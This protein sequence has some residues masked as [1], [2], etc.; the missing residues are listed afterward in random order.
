MYYNSNADGYIK[1]H[2]YLNIS[3]F[4]MHFKIQFLEDESNLNSEFTCIGLG[5]NLYVSNVISE[6]KPTMYTSHFV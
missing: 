3:P 6:Y 4:P 1:H 5:G 2:Y